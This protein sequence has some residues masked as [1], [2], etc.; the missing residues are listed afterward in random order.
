[1]DKIPFVDLS[2][3][4]FTIKDEIDAAIAAVIAETEFI[5]GRYVEKFEQEFAQFLGIQHAV[6]VANGT[7]AL[8][9]AL[10][11]L[12]VGPGDEVLV[13]AQSFIAT[14]EAVSAVGALPVFVDIDAE[15]FCIDPN[16]IEQK[17]NSK[18]KAIVPVHLY[19]LSADM[20]AIMKIATKHNLFVVEDVAQAHAARCDGTLTGTWGHAASFSF[21]PGKNLGAYGDAG[22]V[23]SKDEQL[24]IRMRK[25]ANHGRVGKYDHE[26]EGRNS[27]L[28][29]M[30]AAILSIKLKR[31]N[32]WSEGRRRVAEQYRQGLA[33]T[34]FN[35]PFTPSNYEH[36]YHL[37]VVQHEKRDAVAKLLGAHGI[38]S[39]VHYPT[40]LPFLKAYAHRG[41][42]AKD[43]PVAHKQ[44]Q[45][46][47]SLPIYPELPTAA[48]A[49]VVEVLS[50][51][52]TKEG[53]AKYE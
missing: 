53:L 15:T 46:I 43:F 35:L 11:A 34:D 48:V 21:F 5:K 17:I 27:R 19:G 3:Q 2:A 4:Y 31:L 24:A 16:L 49:R 23:V 40:A 12:G 1:M 29:G 45:S 36:V 14:S 42:T 7:D 47:L 52:A 44:M 20:P 8:E 9:I 18:T 50:R 13:P 38:A 25:I 22:M 37:F 6:G 51:A 32:D 26:F 30:Q 10:K 28:D 33:N 41:A 39:G